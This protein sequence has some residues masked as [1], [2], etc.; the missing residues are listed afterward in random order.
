MFE[1]ERIS[2]QSIILEVVHSIGPTL[3]TIFMPCF[4]LLWKTYNFIHTGRWS[5]CTLWS[6]DS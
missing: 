1:L 2:N 4:K 3:Y 5:F 6:Y